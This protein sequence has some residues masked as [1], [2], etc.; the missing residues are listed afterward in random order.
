MSNKKKRIWIGSTFLIVLSFLLFYR[1]PVIEVAG[2]NTSFFINDDEFVLG[3]IHSIEKEEWFERYQRQDRKILLT[4][5]HFKTYGAGTPY[6]AKETSTENGF[7]N[8]EVHIDY[9]ELNLTISKY[10]QTTLFFSGREVPLYRYFDQYE[11]VIMKT[12]NLPIWE[13]I[14]GDFL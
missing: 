11:N 13:Y 5:T 8:M 9:E 4:E 12:R 2:D 14:R 1:I 3:W 7:I 6:Q 10:V